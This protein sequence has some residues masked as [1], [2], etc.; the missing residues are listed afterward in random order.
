MAIAGRQ[1]PLRNHG[2]RRWGEAALPLTRASGM[3]PLLNYLGSLGAP[4]ARLLEAAGIPSALAEE[5]EALVPLVLVHR[6]VEG[7]VRWTGVGDIGVVLGRRISAF[8]L[9]AFGALLSRA[10][11]VFDYLQT[12]SRL[13]GSVTSGERFWLTREGDLVRFHHF[14]PGEVGAGRCQGDLYAIVVTICMLR[15]FLGAE[16]SPREVCLLA[17]D[18][19]MIGDGSVFGAAEV[20]LSQA[21]SSFTLHRS[22]LQQAIPSGAKSGSASPVGAPLLKPDMP[23][24]AL[25]KLEALVGSL[26][27]AR[28]LD[29]EVVAEAAGSS[30]RSLQ[31]HLQAV[32]LSYSQIVET[33]RT[34]RACDWLAS[35]GMPIAEIADMLG[36]S[37]PAHFSRA[38]RRQTGISP[39][40]F[41]N[42]HR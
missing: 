8:D 16:W 2:T 14:Q 22:L 3:A 37:D 27:M 20:R 17:T 1:A 15:R 5:S 30:T 32:G 26:L 40:Q 25:E 19:S 34:R 6:L 33:T 24:D 42:Q 4:T 31:R 35:G 29:I 13:I 11:S 9:G 7:S 28:C 10:V 23:A 18:P 41:R 12:G 21:H 36:Y 39:Q 38:F